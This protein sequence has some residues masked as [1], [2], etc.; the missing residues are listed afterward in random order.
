MMLLGELL[1]WEVLRGRLF[2]WIIIERQGSK[3]ARQ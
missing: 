1:D 3:A 2:E